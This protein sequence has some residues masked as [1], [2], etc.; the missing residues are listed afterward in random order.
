MKK[1][2]LLLVIFTLLPTPAFAYIGPGAGLGAIATFIAI[3]LGVILLIVGFVWYPLKR[4][5]N[6]RRKTKIK[7][8]SE[9]VSERE[10]QC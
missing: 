8:S 7:S 3:V 1:F 6:K 5:L 10:N 4:I 9:S 2:Q